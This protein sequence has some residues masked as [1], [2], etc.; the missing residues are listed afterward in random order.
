MKPRRLR[1][2][3]LIA[4]LFPQIA[5]VRAEW[6]SRTED[7]IMGTRVVV[8]LWSANATVGN[9]AIAAVI[10]EMNRI[11]RDMSTYKADSEIS[12]VNAAAG[13]V[14]VKISDELF[15]LLHT[16]LEYSRIT[17]GAFDITYASVGFMYDFREHKRPTEDQ[18]KSALPAV[19]YRHIV[20]DEK[21]RTVRF[22]Q[23]RVRIDLGGIGKGHA[24]DRGIAILQS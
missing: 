13:K 17:N 16:A 24:V 7:G 11:D 22:T 6:L 2:V 5:S 14:A 1:F 23:P 4:A 9:Q 20:L 8:E 18:I 15:D 12:R 3:L 19:S 10:D 21:N